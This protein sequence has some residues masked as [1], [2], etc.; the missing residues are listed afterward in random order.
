MHDCDPQFYY[1]TNPS[2]LKQ[3][4]VS[5]AIRLILGIA[6]LLADDV[7]SNAQGQRVIADEFI[8]ALR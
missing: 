7:P 1:P 4:P 8:N 6:V 3:G 2:L 5:R